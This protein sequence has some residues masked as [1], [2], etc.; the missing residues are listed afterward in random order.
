MTAMAIEADN[1]TIN[2]ATIRE[3][4]QMS[5]LRLVLGAFA[6]PAPWHQACLNVFRVKGLEFTP[7]RASNEDASDLMIGMDGSQ[8]ELIEWTAQSSAPVAVWNDERPRTLWNDQLYLAERLAPEPALIPADIGER[9]LM[10]GLANELLGEGGLLFRKRHFMTAVPAQSLPEDSP[11]RAL[12]DFLGQKYGY[13]EAAV[14][15]AETR[16]VEILNTF[17]AHLKAQ[18]DRGSRYLVGE[19]FSALDIYWSTSCGF[20]DPLPEDQCPMA[21]AFRQPHLYGCPTPAIDKALSARLRAHRDFIYE[22]HLELPIV[23]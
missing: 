3:A 14:A 11:E 8:S 18:H 4:R 15:T 10:F 5:G 2:Y 22:T 19:Q 6:V 16:I 9:M 1:I 23:F 17:D 7:V 13:S 12:F 20:L 21:T